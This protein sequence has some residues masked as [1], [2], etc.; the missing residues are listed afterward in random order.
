MKKFIIGL[1]MFFGSMWGGA[2]L[3]CYSLDKNSWIYFPSFMTA[4][5]IAG[6]GLILAIIAIVNHFDLQ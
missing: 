2:Y 3:V 1:M 4:V 5:L 6:G